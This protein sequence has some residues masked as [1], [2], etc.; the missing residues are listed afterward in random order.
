MTVPN[1]FHETWRHSSLPQVVLLTDENGKLLSWNPAAQEI[2]GYPEREVLGKSSSLLLPELNLS[3]EL[4]RSL[5]GETIATIGVKNGGEKVPLELTLTFYE[6]EG[7]RLIAALVSDLTA[8]QIASKRT[9]LRDRLVS[10]GQLA[11]GMAHD[12]NNILGTI[13]LFSELMLG[14]DDIQERVKER[15]E[16]IL[17]QAKRGATL[18]TQVLD[19]SRRSVVKR[20]PLDLRQFLTDVEQLLKRTMPANIRLAFDFDGESFHIK[21]DPARMQQIVMNLALNA[22]D[23]MPS[24][25]DMS[26]EISRLTVDPDERPPYRDMQS[27]DW[28]CMRVSDSGVGIAPETLPHIFEPFFTTKAHGEGTGL[29]LAQVYGIVKRHEG[30]IDVES[31]LGAGTSFIIYL[32]LTEAEAPESQSIESSKKETGET[33]TVLVVEDNEPSRIAMV[34]ILEYLGCTVLQAGTGQEAIAQLEEHAATLDLVICDM[35]LPDIDGNAIARRV[36]KFD[37][38][39][40]VVLMTG[41]A[42][43]MDT[44]ELTLEESHIW[45]T[46]PFTTE[47]IEA[48][49]REALG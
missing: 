44:Q 22:R 25:G 30:Y 14:W 35:I 39:P 34:A 11:A 12:F 43:S 40:Q 48:V 3:E 2:F 29:G 26:F 18:T 17:E 31:E 38:A 23:A 6:G 49:L 28:V 47:D 1:N 16:T 37:P 45:L 27:G 13:I 20:Q 21:A 24:G 8:A 36:R 33:R 4:W 5:N 46:K 41:Y 19:F 42:P 7:Q 15:L 9:F 32:P 10:V